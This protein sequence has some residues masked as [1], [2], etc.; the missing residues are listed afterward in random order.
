MYII[1]KA[2]ITYDF[3]MHTVCITI[4]I[5]REIYG[6]YISE[7]VFHWLTGRTEPLGPRAFASPTDWETR[8]HTSTRQWEAVGVAS[9]GGSQ[10]I[11][12]LRDPKMVDFLR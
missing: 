10:Q 3:V 1:P 2:Y 5:Y 7:S 12:S 9:L 6:D 8:K 4:Y 11:H